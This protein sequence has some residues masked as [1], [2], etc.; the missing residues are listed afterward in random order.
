MV[1]A[2][3]KRLRGPEKWWIIPPRR[4]GGLSVQSLQG[5]SGITSDRASSYTRQANAR[6]HSVARSPNRSLQGHPH[7]RRVSAAKSCPAIRRDS[8]GGEGYQVCAC[9]SRTRSHG[10]IKAGQN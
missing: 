1:P 3:R 5:S 8:A 6:H 10:K 9:P 4:T 7:C 2:G